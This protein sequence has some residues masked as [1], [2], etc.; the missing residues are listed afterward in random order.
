MRVFHHRRE[1]NQYIA[2]LKKE[3]KSIGFVPTM[4]ALHAGH[5]S[6]VQ[7]AKQQN[8]ITVVSIFVNP[9]QFNNREDLVHYPRTLNTDLP[10][11]EKEGCD[12]VFIPDEKEIYPE[13][14]LR[15]FSFGNLDKV[16]EG[17]HRPGHFNGVAQIVTKLFDII[18]P[19]RAYFGL[20]DF[21][22]VA[23]IRKLA[24]D[25]AYP[26]EIIACPIVR[27]ADGLALSS[28]NLRLSPE[29]RQHAALISKTL[30]EAQRTGTSVSVEKMKKTVLD[31]INKD[32]YLQVEYFEIVDDKTLQPVKAWEKPGGKVGCIAVNA[33]DVRLI[34]NITFN[35]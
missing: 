12:I 5:I 8:D 18:A 3:G 23:I 22:Q 20:K 15:V 27:E 9:T 21:Q 26:V 7:C 34:D 17:K 30:F 35:S 31:T 29:Q 1:I 2:S 33:G 4:G 16:L 6:L 14:D 19:H 25:C 28:R 32:P 10:M 11:L 24:E 13:P